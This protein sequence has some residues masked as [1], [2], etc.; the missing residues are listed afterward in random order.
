[1]AGVLLLLGLQNGHCNQASDVSWRRHQYTS[2]WFD[3]CSVLRRRKHKL[4]AAHLKL[5]RRSLAGLG[6]K[7]LKR[8]DG[9][10]KYIANAVDKSGNTCPREQ[11]MM[12][13][14]LPGSNFGRM[15][16]RSRT[17]TQLITAIFGTFQFSNCNLKDDKYHSRCLQL[18]EDVRYMR[19]LDLDDGFWAK[20]DNKSEKLLTDEWAR[21]YY[22]HSQPWKIT[23]PTL[24][25]S[26][27]STWIRCTNSC[28]TTWAN[29]TR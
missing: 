27:S 29:S 3:D 2:F 20:L 6:C 19:Q 22:K 9:G 8:T 13:Y 25:S 14:A 4:D 5:A 12:S 7:K 16:P 18:Q 17:H 23:S 1:M 15:W 10:N 21:G 28:G 26:L 11:L 24:H